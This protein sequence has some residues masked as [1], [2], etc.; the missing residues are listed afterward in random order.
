MNQSINDKATESDITITESKT[1]VDGPICGTTAID[2][3]ERVGHESHVTTTLSVDDIQSGSLIVEEVKDDSAKANRK[4]QTTNTESGSIV[5]G[6]EVDDDSVSQRGNNVSRTETN[7]DEETNDPVDCESRKMELE[8]EIITPTNNM[9]DTTLIKDET[10]ESSLTFDY[11][12]SDNDS[13]VPSLDTKHETVSSKHI[14][15]ENGITIISIGSSTNEMSGEDGETYTD[16][17]NSAKVKDV[18]PNCSTKN[19][20]FI[21]TTKLKHAE[22]CQ[23]ETFSPSITQRRRKGKPLAINSSKLIKGT[24]TKSVRKTLKPIYYVPKCKFKGKYIG[25]MTRC[26][27]CMRWHHDKCIDD[28]SEENKL[29]AVRLCEYCRKTP[30]ITKDLSQHLASVTSLVIEQNTTLLEIKELAEEQKLTSEESVAMQIQNIS[31]TKNGT[32]ILMDMIEHMKRDQHETAA[33]T[34]KQ[35]QKQID[36]N[37][38]LR[39]RLHVRVKQSMRHS[40][41]IRS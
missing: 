23:D 13:A 34:L 28:I 38:N 14:V 37:E 4:L 15:L 26:C 12:I 8:N 5:D 2:N 6:E 41:R 18:K 40:T 39:Q 30:E 10:Q 33:E 31:E 21:N 25:H 29:S 36:E 11:D 24:K 19:T 1:V 7:V 35:N 9:N 17:K 3:C 22:K 32:S 16:K 20:T 27:L